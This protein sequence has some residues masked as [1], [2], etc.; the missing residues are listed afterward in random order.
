[1]HCVPGVCTAAGANDVANSF[2]PS[3]SSRSLTLMQA[4]GIAAVM[5]FAGAVALGASVTA[6]MRDGIVKTSLFATRPDLLMSGFF[7]ALSSCALWVLL[8]THAG[9]PVSSTQS[10][11]SALAGMG[12]S[13]FGFAAVNWGWSGKGIAQIAAAWVLS[14]VLAGLVASTLFVLTR[15]FILKHPKSL[16][17]GIFAI[18]IYFTLTAFIITFYIVIRNGKGTLKIATSGTG[19][20]VTVT[21]NVGLAFGIIGACTAAVLLF[22]GGLV[23][24]FFYRRL[25]KEEQLKWYELFYIWCVPEHP[26]DET[27]EPWLKSYF[28]PHLLTRRREA[29]PGPSPTLRPPQR[30]H[31]R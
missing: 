26:R 6:T 12:V 16:I 30:R 14:P 23:C 13:A 25:V 29:G 8:A 19:G 4:M 22:C 17:R 1:M 28:T 20:A 18:P 21:G 5:E 11:I 15:F 9:W 7:A 24:P 2:A 27:L 31:L 10:I 3:V